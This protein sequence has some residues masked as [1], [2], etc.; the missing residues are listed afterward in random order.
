MGRGKN[1]ER[2]AEDHGAQIMPDVKLT[3][4]P[5]AR[6][7]LCTPEVT[8]L[9][10]ELV[11]AGLTIPVACKAIGVSKP[12]WASWNAKGRK[13]EAD[14]TDSQY[15]EWW[16]AMCEAKAS[17]EAN[18]IRMVSAGS[19]SDWKAAAWVLERRYSKRWGKPEHR[20]ESDAG[21]DLTAASTEELQLMLVSGGQRLGGGTL[22]LSA[23]EPTTGAL[24]APTQTSSDD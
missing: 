21:D 11:A 13:H 23:A 17:C 3:Y 7:T 22:S 19:A 18:L 24:T 8:R 4:R 9:V 1:Y 6:P 16:E 20:P 12:S 15:R 2:D 5:A 14:G 10:A